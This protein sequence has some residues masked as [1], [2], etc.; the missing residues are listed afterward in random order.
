MEQGVHNASYR[1]LLRQLEAAPG[2][3]RLAG[4]LLAAAV[5][6]SWP[7]TRRQQKSKQSV[8][9]WCS[10]CKD[11]KETSFHRVWECEARKPHDIYKL[12]DEFAGRAQAGREAEE[13]FWV[14]G[15]IPSSWLTVPEPIQD[16]DWICYGLEGGGLTDSCF[17]EGSEVAPTFIFGDASGGEDSRDAG[18]R[19]VGLAV[20]VYADLN[21]DMNLEIGVWGGLPGGTQTVARGELYALYVAARGGRG[22]V[23]FVTD[24]AAVCS[25]W[26]ANNPANPCGANADLWFLI[27][28][29]VREKREVLAITVVFVHSHQEAIDMCD[30]RTPAPFILGNAVADELAGIAAK[31]VR[32]AADVRARVYKT[33]RM[34]HCVRMRI[35]L[36]TLE[37]IEAEKEHEGPRPRMRQPGPRPPAPMMCSVF[38]SQ[39]LLNDSGSSCCRCKGS[40]SQAQKKAWLDSPCF[41]LTSGGSSAV[42]DPPP[43][44]RVHVGGGYAHESHQL[45]FHAGLGIWFCT[46]CGSFAAEQL[47]KLSKECDPQR[48]RYDY[49]DRIQQG[50]WPK[51]YSRAE[52]AKRAAAGKPV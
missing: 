28:K 20:A 44:S 27:G 13:C 26:Y 14:R 18:L 25:G 43:G 46:S 2:G 47:A 10:R 24:N 6:A 35:L 34:A 42:W 33:E 37:V 23:V 8:S 3:R 9:E 7:R 32:V 15:L 49:L 19:R 41:S 16:E 45:K 12:S 40:T 11:C 52:R 21:Y 1:Q 5:G 22:H 50:L 30:G 36:S 48:S 39:H 31:Q 38:H 29:T 4:L 17:P 51:L